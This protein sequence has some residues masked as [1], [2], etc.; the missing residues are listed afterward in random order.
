MTGWVARASISLN[1]VGLA[2]ADDTLDGSAKGWSVKGRIA[3]KLTLDSGKQFEQP[4]RFYQTALDHLM[5]VLLVERMTSLDFR[6]RLR[7]EIVVKEHKFPFLLDETAPLLP[8]G[9]LGNKVIRRRQL[10]VHLETFL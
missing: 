3:I 2:F 5:N 1:R 4:L 8:P 10:D 6:E 9:Q 7:V